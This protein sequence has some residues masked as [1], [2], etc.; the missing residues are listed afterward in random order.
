MSDGWF[1]LHRCLQSHWLWKDKPFSYGQAWIDLLMMVNYKETKVLMD[2]KLVVVPAGSVITSE[3]KLSERWGWGRTKLR[4]FLKLLEDDGMIVKNATNKQT[5]INVVNWGKYQLPQTADEQQTN[6]RRTADEQ[7]TNTNNNIN[8]NKNNNKQKERKV[9]TPPTLEE[10]R[11]YCLERGNKVNPE[12]FFDYYSA[13]GWVQ[14][15]GKP[16]KDWKACMRTWEGKEQ[17]FNRQP[18]DDFERKM[19]ILREGM[20]S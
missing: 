14:G 6:S 15:K 1:S 2:A 20:T 19:R 3:V 12:R 13:N 5:T 16:I 4:G 17:E 18:E 8:N 9:F 10:V 7:Q 11:A